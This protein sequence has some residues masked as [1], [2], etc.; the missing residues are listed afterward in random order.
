MPQITTVCTSCSAPADAQ[1]DPAT[2]ARAVV[3]LNH[4]V[5]VEDPCFVADTIELLDGGQIIF[6]P[7]KREG[8]YDQYSVICRKLYVSGG[9]PP[10]EGNPC[11][12]EDPGT[13]Y[14]GR[15]L[16]TWAGRLRPAATGTDHV[17][18]APDGG[19]GPGE[20]PFDP[21]TW[22]DLGQ[23]DHG[24]KGHRGHDGQQGGAGGVG[25]H[26][27]GIQDLRERRPVLNLVVLEV[28]ITA[29]SHLIV[30]WD[31]QA[32]GNGG[33]GQNGGRG[34]PGMGGHDGSTDESVWGDSCERAPGNG[35][36]AGDGGNGGSGGVGGRG[37]DAGDIFVISTLANVATGGPLKASS[38]HYVNG[39]AKGGTGGQ[40]GRGGQA[41]PI[42]GRKGKKTSECEE[43]QNGQPGS[44][45][46]PEPLG[47]GGLVDGATGAN[48]NPG[49][50]SFEVI[51]PPK[52]GT[53][54][55]DIPLP[56]R[57][58][59][60]SPSSGTRGSTVA[61]TITGVGFGGGATPQVLVSGAG[62]TVGAVTSTATTLNCDFTI[63]NLAPQNARDV[64][65][66]VS[67]AMAVTAVGAFTV[68]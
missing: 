18:A 64:T 9:R 32:G 5:F 55:D 44:A 17:T 45:G 16:I 59:S 43:A 63:G 15:N 56:L 3:T 38:V 31:G 30:D 7:R 34:G 54:A 46:L 21:N 48:G 23:G 8:Y 39:G 40:G 37:G 10:K 33:R 19:Q 41:S 13:N 12:P 25:S 50:L 60:V 29:G 52:T 4:P 66:R 53:C 26:A 6:S 11:R 20:T 68:A 67:P 35:G 1:F 57:I 47:Q 49:K 22:Q 65:V 14:E 27:L 58:S 2:G 28:E 62:V 51:E 24:A 61:V 42:A 36:N